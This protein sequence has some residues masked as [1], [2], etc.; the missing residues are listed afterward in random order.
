MGAAFVQ[1]HGSVLETLR[2][3]GELPDAVTAIASNEHYLWVGTMRGLVRFELRP[4]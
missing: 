1:P 4:R 2:V 3:G